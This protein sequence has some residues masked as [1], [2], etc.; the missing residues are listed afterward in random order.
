[1]PSVSHGWRRGPED[2]AIAGKDAM[3]KYLWKGDH[4]LI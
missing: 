2:V 3:P 1:M 4:Y